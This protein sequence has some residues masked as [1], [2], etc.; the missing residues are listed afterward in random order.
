MTDNYRD[1]IRFLGYAVLERLSPASCEVY[2]V[3][4][5]GKLLVAKVGDQWYNGFTYKHVVREHEVLERARAIEGVPQEHFFRTY[6]GA[7]DMA[8]L[9]KEYL[10]GRTLEMQNTFSE[11][12]KDDLISRIRVF[13][14]QGMADLDIHSSGRNVLITPEGKPRLIDLGSVQLESE[15]PKESFSNL[16]AV[17]LRGAEYLYTSFNKAD[18]EY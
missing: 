12:Q 18:T 6:R 1:F 10:E 8:L 14:N 11:T 2:K 3:E 4:R 5:E 15:L 17:D 13:H 16:K 7:Q 9:I